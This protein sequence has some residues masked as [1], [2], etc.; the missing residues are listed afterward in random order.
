MLPLS[1]EQLADIQQA[2]V[3]IYNN[4]NY[5]F[6]IM[7]SQHRAFTS[8]GNYSTQHL[9]SKLWLQME[10]FIHDWFWE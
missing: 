3:Q 5:R 6:E 10:P 2:I 8:Y 4:N 9:T 1:D 7:Q